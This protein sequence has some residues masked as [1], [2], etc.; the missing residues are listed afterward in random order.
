MLT[1]LFWYS[2]RQ[3]CA[4]PQRVLALFETLDARAQQQ[5]L[6]SRLLAQIRYFG[7]RADAL[8]EWREAAR[9]SDPEELW[10]IWPS[11][12]ILT[13]SMLNS[14]FDPVEMQQRFKLCGRV[15][16][17]GGSTG[18]PTRFFLD[19]AMLRASRAVHMFTQL[20]MGWR[21]GMATV[22]VWGAERDIGKNTPM[23]QRL[24]HRL[25]NDY[26]VGGFAIDDGAVKKVL[27]LIAAQQPIAMYGFSSLLEV[28][29]ERT[30]A[31]GSQPRAGAVAVA[32]NGGEMLYQRQ[33]DIFRKAFG[34]PVLNRYGGRELS[35]MACQYESGGPLCVLRPLLFL[36]VVDSD[37]RPA[38]PG[39]P[40]RLV[41]TSTVCRGT[42]F[43]RY[44]VGDLG[45]FTEAN[46]DESGIRSL[47]ELH[48]RHAG[49]MRLP[50]GRIISCLYWNHLLKDYPEVK[51]FQVRIRSGYPLSI[52][53]T[54]RRFSSRRAEE[55]RSALCPVLRET[56]VELTWV[57]TIPRTSQGKQIQVLYE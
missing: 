12:P 10:R 50:D 34:V 30:I 4:A 22:I 5:L 31:L 37:G 35:A 16:A 20:K 52:L 51:Q 21:P 9:I 13:K 40:G 28:V 8:P 2:Y 53:H 29:A 42:P 56:P 33:I 18:E 7:A 36:E 27:A 46:R 47:C 49:A 26:V 15:S 54:G 45:A 48:G 24:A 41:W 38:L 6:A 44:D 14:R 39:Q 1:N 57:E 43:L 19:T 11:L 25:S 23:R 32:W 55:L 3:S 17:T